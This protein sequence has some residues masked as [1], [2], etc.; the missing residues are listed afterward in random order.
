MIALV[1]AVIF[2]FATTGNEAEVKLC[3]PELGEFLKYFIWYF[4]FVFARQMVVLILL[5]LVKHP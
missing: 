4:N 1:I 3:S 5:L 2:H